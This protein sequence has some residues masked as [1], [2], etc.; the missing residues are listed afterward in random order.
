[1]PNKLAHFAIE[2]DDVQRARNFYAAVFGWTFEPWGP[3]DFYLIHGAGVHGALQKRAGAAPEANAQ[4]KRGYECTI[5]VDD[6]GATLALVEGNGGTIAGGSHKLPT[7]GELA[8]FTDTE[9][10]GALLMQYEPE[11]LKEM[12]L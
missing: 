10:N 2:A 5:A 11:R 9:G 7:V 6:L 3:P 8:S 4:S 1:M 12:S